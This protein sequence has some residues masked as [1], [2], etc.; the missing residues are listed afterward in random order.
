[1]LL[2]LL[3]LLFSA[4]NAVCQS[5]SSLESATNAAAAQGIWSISLKGTEQVTLALHQEADSLFGSASS[6]GD[7]PWNAAALGLISGD[8]IELTMTSIQSRSIICTRLIGTVSGDSFNG[9]FVSAD[10]HGEADSG[11]FTAVMINPDITAYSPA[12]VVADEEAAD[13][14][15]KT[16]A[17]KNTQIATQTTEQTTTQT[18]PTQ[19]G[20]PKYRDV[21]TMA[22]MVPENLGV[23]FIGDGTMGAGGMGMG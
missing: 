23:G 1:M 12:K 8:K 3:M 11:I 4:G 5:N 19:L 14:T 10:D 18:Q 2:F 16:P 9:R 13:N 22:G 7:R 20:N 6:D 15:S 17:A 21:H